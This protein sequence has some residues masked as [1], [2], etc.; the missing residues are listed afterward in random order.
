MTEAAGSAH[1]LELSDDEAALARQV[2]AGLHRPSPWVYWVDLITS[3]AVGWSAFTVTC[4]APLWS[5]LMIGAG[6]VAFLALYRALAF[7]HEL[8]HQ[9]DSTLPGFAL[10]WDAMVGVPLMFPSVLHVGVHVNHHK[11][12]TYG[13]DQDPEYYH[14]GESVLAA[15]GFLI[16]NALLPVLWGVR[17]LLLAPAGLFYPPLGRYLQDRATSL[18]MSPSYRRDWPERDRARAVRTELAIL[19]FWGAVLALAAAGV[20]PWRALAIWAVIT[21][22]ATC[23]NALR[24]LGAHRYCNSGEPLDRAGQLLDS[25]DTPGGPWTELWAPV[26][27]RYHALHHFFP[28]IPY[29]HLGTA[30]RR[31]LEVLPPDSPYRATT[32]RGLARSLLALVTDGCRSI[33][34]R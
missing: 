14:H 30:H 20:L 29:H 22:S 23:L 17:F 3:A 12:G 2:V 18:S 32:S 31:L 26:G 33:Q 11:L 27:L 15:L 1:R 13:T 7:L 21:G 24:T 5:P 16:L 9:T 28:G 10:A 4:F 19:A 34:L 8:S 25:I 6:I